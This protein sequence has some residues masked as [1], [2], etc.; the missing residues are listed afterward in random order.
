[1]ADVRPES[2][3][4]LRTTPYN[5]VQLRIASPSLCALRNVLRP[6]SA[7]KG[8]NAAAPPLDIPAA[9]VLT[10]GALTV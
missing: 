1:M 10:C 7:A 9:A 6:L 5:S 8:K 2:C 3:T 4:F